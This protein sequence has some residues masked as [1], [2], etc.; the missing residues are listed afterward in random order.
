MST[1]VNNT[2]I[3]NNISINNVRNSTITI[4]QSNIGPVT[5][6]TSLSRK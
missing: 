1:L 2:A 4:T 6:T 5:A 3:A